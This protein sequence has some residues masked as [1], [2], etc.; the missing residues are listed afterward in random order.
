VAGIQNP[1]RECVY[2]PFTV[3][4]SVRVHCLAY[5][6]L[7]IGMSKGLSGSAEGPLCFGAPGAREGRPN[8]TLFT[9]RARNSAKQ[10]E[11]VDRGAAPGGACAVPTFQRIEQFFEAPVAP[12]AAIMNLP[13]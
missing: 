13:A 2:R 8:E 5:P 6:V 7:R 4:G 10:T 1:L 12:S 11:A 3:A 9:V